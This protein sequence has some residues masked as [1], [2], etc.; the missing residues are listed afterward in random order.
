MLVD[1]LAGLRAAH[2]SWS[3][4]LV[5]AG[6]GP[7]GARVEALGVPVETLPFPPAV[8]RLGDWGLGP[9][10]KGRLQFLWRCALAN[11]PALAY[12]LRLRRRLRSLSPTI[13][14]TNGL[15]MHLLG[16]WAS[17]PTSSVVWHLHD[18]LG[19][20]AATSR[21]LRWSAGHCAAIVAN[22]RSVAADARGV[23]ANGPGV[24]PV[25]NAVD[26]ERFSPNGPRL[27]LDARAG[28]P[29]AED[30]LR[31]GLV[32]TFAAWK[33][34]TVFLEALA[35]LSRQL[36]VRGYIVGGPIYETAGSEVTLDALRARAGVLGIADRVGFTGFVDDA[37]AAMRALD[38]VVHAS[39]DPEPFGLVIAEAMACGRPVIVS[40]AGGASELADTEADLPTFLPGDTAELA[41]QIEL[42]ATDSSLRE[43][44]GRE[45]RRT[46]E[47]CFTVSRMAGEFAAVYEALPKA[48]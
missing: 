30:V 20:R 38:V 6:G 47:R 28:L 8:A 39:T 4:R 32:A 46:A 10:L 5:M 33:G 3:L 29:P 11:G 15:K 41:R 35:R 43:R 14:H 12:L 31:V 1:L 44:L 40:R 9:G 26:L 7:L 16:A 37:S 19:R 42:L 18:Y 36:R 34:H 2:P 22:S 21:L 13:V 45:G 23:L 17:P 27:D 24:R 25:W 48:H